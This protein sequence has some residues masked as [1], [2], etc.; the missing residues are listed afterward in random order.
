[1]FK[2]WKRVRQEMKKEAEASRAIRR[3][4]RVPLDYE[5]LQTLIDV[6]QNN[7]GVKIRVTLV[8]GS[9][10]DMEPASKKGTEFM[11]F[12]EKYMNEHK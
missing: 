1:M 11:S 7:G 2:L 5:M 4:A 6:A 9:T 3:L 10:L 8:D 12:K